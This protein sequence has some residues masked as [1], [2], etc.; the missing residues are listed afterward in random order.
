M[1]EVITMDEKEIEL[2]KSIEGLSKQV[3]SLIY[4]LGKSP[5]LPIQV[6]MAHFETNLKTALDNIT[7]LKTSFKEISD[8]KI[9]LKEIVGDLKVALKEVA[10]LKSS[11]KETDKQAEENTREI[12]RIK[13]KAGLLGTVAGM[14]VAGVI[15]LMFKFF[16]P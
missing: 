4:N 15:S 1:P 12:E 2:K 16:S 7:E 10:E 5:D 9:V 11:L 6:K 14:I 8:L 13:V 3:E